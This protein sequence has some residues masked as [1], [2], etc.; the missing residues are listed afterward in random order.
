MFYVYYPD[1]ACF[2][3]HCKMCSHLRLFIYPNRPRDQKTLPPW[4]WTSLCK[5]LWCVCVF[6][7]NFRRSSSVGARPWRRPFSPWQRRRRRGPQGPK[8]TACPLPPPQ[9]PSLSPALPRKK[10]RR[11]SVALPRRS[12]RR[13]ETRPEGCLGNLERESSICI[14]SVRAS[15]LEFFILFCEN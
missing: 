2:K 14:Q 1:L 10:R 4:R 9:L 15:F 8:P 12:E 5:L 13:W 6:V 3:F 7:L 11:S